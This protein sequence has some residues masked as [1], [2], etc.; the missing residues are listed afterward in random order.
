L[1]SVIDGEK[2]ANLDRVRPY[3]PSGEAQED[4]ANANDQDNYVLRKL[5]KKSGKIN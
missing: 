1:F 3:N 5:L 2:I 4:E